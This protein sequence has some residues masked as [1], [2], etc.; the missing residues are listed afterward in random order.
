MWDFNV[1]QNNQ[2]EAID[3]DKERDETEN[4]TEYNTRFGDK[5]AEVGFILMKTCDLQIGSNSYLKV[6]IEM[7]ILK[8][9]DPD[10]ILV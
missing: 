7:G 8:T 6:K 4:H 2:E 1:D 5:I 3:V 10:D 9:L